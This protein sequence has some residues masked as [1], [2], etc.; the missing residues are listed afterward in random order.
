M[1]QLIAY[2]ERKK[3]GKQE[4][5][6]TKTTQLSDD[7]SINNSLL[8]ENG[9][10]ES[11]TLTVLESIKAQSNHCQDE[12]EDAIPVVQILATESK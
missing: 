9:E 6:H 1:H 3:T 12:D 5:Q 11:E 8:S 7:R 2:P 4:P 10:K